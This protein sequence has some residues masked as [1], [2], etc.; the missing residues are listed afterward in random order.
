MDLA[1]WQM[2]C[3]YLSFNDL[4]HSYMLHAF[5]VSLVLVPNFLHFEVQE[6]PR[7]GCHMKMQTK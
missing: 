4:W 1:F 3:C 7:Q 5:E 6:E 2:M